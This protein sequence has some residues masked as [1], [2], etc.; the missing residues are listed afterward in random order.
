[1]SFAWFAVSFDYYLI[2]FLI[3]SF[4]HAY[5]ASTASQIAE[6]ASQFIGGLLFQTIGAKK[7]FFITF[8]MSAVAGIIIIFYG[9]YNQDGY[10]FLVLILASKFGI[11]C[12]FAIV[13]VAHISIFPTM[14]ATSSFGFCNF[15]ARLF[16]I[17]SPLLAQMNGSVP[18]ICFSV[19]AGVAAILVLFL[20][21]DEDHVDVKKVHQSK[22]PKQ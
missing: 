1:M 21:T 18:M 10:M 17:S 7:S 11:S 8:A 19:T 12:S 20:Q 2:N 22:E 5:Q 9:Q 4:K 16:T 3:T 14:F 6:I 15:F 13:Y